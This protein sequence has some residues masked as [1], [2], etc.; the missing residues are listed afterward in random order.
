MSSRQDGCLIP[1]SE[2]L[3]K[4]EKFYDSDCFP[5]PSHSLITGNNWTPW[6][7]S[8]LLAHLVASGSPCHRSIEQMACS[9]DKCAGRGGTEGFGA[10]ALPWSPCLTAY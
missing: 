3:S 1:F 9:S 10:G 8:R 2:V 6:E 7:K 5:T 4:L